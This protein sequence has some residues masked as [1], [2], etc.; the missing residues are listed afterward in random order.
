MVLDQRYVFIGSANIDPRSNTLNTEIGVM[1][2]SRELA[3]EATILFERTT[4]PK[5]SYRLLLEQQSSARRV[6][7]LTEEDGKKTTYVDEPKAGFFRK[8]GVFIMGLLP[9]ESLL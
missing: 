4:S 8:L 6:L 9:I 5:N 2:D 7:W 3:K 1:V